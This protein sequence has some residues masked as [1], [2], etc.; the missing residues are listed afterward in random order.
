M[1]ITLPDI[2]SD[3]LGAD[4]LIPWALLGL[5]SQD[6]VRCLH[7]RCLRH[8]TGGRVARLQPAM[9][10]KR[11]VSLQIP[12]KYLGIDYGYSLT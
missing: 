9:V 11:A 4:G 10:K 1:S 8:L 6:A 7:M 12:P 3:L 2:T 5:G